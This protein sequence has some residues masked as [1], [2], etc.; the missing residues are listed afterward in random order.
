MSFCTAN[1]SVERRLFDAVGGFDPAMQYW[2]LDDTDLGYRLHIAQ[3]RG[4]HSLRSA[5][6]HLDPEGSGAGESHEERMRSYRLHMEVLY[7]KHLSSSI[8]DSFSFLQ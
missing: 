5:V 6:V 4:W 2:G 7:R 1:V 8:L 3:A